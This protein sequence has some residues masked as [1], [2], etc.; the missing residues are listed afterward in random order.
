MFLTLFFLEFSMSLD[1]CDASFLIL[2][3]PVG[4]NHLCRHVDC[5][6]GNHAARVNRVAAEEPAVFLTRLWVDKRCHQEPD[7]IAGSSDFVRV[8]GTLVV[9]REAADVH[10]DCARSGI[11]PADELL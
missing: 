8:D 5:P 1:M 9:C 3:H 4:K 6:L 7:N 10:G 11:V 2:L